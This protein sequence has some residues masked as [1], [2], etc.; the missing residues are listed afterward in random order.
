M[1]DV[2]DLCRVGERRLSSLHSELDEVCINPGGLD[3]FR[4][5]ELQT[6]LLMQNPDSVATECFFG[7]N[8][9]FKPS[10]EY[11]FE[12]EAIASFVNG[13]FVED[14]RLRGILPLTAASVNEVLSDGIV[15]GEWCS[16]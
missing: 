4:V 7:S 8:G 12:Q 5:S 16:E 13:R 9:N 1:Q 3:E 10:V 14:E 2:A 15:L 6:T 11:S